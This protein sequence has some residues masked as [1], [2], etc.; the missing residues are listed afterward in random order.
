MKTMNTNEE[1]PEYFYVFLNFNGIHN[2]INGHNYNL[3]KRILSTGIGNVSSKLYDAKAFYDGDIDYLPFVRTNKELFM[4]SSFMKNKIHNYNI[5]YN[6]EYYRKL[7]YKNY[8]SRFSGVFAFGSYEACEQISMKYPKWWNI[9]EVKKFRLVRNNPLNKIAK[10]NM[11]IVSLLN[12]VDISAFSIESQ[13]SIY[14]TYWSG[15][16]SVQVERR[17]ILQKDVIYEYLI[18]GCLEEVE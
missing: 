14:N 5:E 1:I 9:E 13:N 12:A 18:E 7:H 3:S 11:E 2:E 6:L 10:L 17:S 15:G 16:G 8:P 4:I